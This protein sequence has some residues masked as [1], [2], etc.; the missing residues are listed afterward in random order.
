MIFVGIIICVISYLVFDFLQCLITLKKSKLPSLPILPLLGHVHHFLGST[1]ATFEKLLDIAKTRKSF[2]LFF[3]SIF[4]PY[5]YDFEMVSHLIKPENQMYQKAAQYDFM[6]VLGQRQIFVDWGTQYKESK[7]VLIEAVSHGNLK[8]YI[9]SFNRN[10]QN[11]VDDLRSK[12]GG[13]V[14]DLK[15]ELDFHA[16]SIL[17]DTIM[18]LEASIMT[19]DEIELFGKEYSKILKYIVRRG[20][21]VWLYPS[22]LYK[23]SNLFKLCNQSVSYIRKVTRKLIESRKE[24]FEVSEL[25]GQKTLRTSVFIDK[26]FVSKKDDGSDFSIEDITDDVLALLGAGFETTVSSLS[27]II[28]MLSINQDVQEKVFEELKEKLKANDGYLD[29]YNLNE[30]QYLDQVIHETWRLHPPVSSI[31]R[32]LTKDIVL[33]NGG[34]LE[35]GTNVWFYITMIHRDPKFYPEP[36]IFNP[37]NFLPER[38]KERPPQVFMPFGFGT[39]KCFG[40]IFAKLVIKTILCHL[41][42]NYQFHTTKTENDFQLAFEITLKN[43]IGVPVSITSRP[44]I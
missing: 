32:L 44:K 12:V 31:G 21:K 35:K 6:R 40:N 36:E 17:L 28:M 33:P 42:R 43:K 18:G 16:I 37:N 8:K 19:R 41:M 30:L 5:I 39:R 20:Y 14:F 23:F 1:N 11:L 7:R 2:A 3:G 38:V 9:T 24:K 22:S 15:A 26:Y 10:A 4:T 13:D 34:Y 29:T 27:L 25:N